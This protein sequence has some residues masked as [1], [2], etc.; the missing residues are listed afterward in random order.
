[1]QLG[2]GRGGLERGEKKEEGEERRKSTGG[3]GERREVVLEE[4]QEEA[5]WLGLPTSSDFQLRRCD[6]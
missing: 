5:G 1:M 3:T 6:T 2:R 4:E